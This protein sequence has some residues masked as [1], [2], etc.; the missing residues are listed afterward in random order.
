M[1]SAPGASV[2]FEDE[3]EA[4]SLM[5]AHQ[6]DDEVLDDRPPDLALLT[7][8]IEASEPSSMAERRG[9]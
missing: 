1:A 5:G 7:W 6:R 2:P 9:A 4:A 3:D 8:T